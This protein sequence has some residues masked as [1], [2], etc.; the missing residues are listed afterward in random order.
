MNFIIISIFVSTNMSSPEIMRVKFDR[1]K[2]LIETDGCGKRIE[3]EVDN[4]HVKSER[5]LQKIVDEAFK[6]CEYK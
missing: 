2:A 1:D 3:F 6:S 4:K 5:L